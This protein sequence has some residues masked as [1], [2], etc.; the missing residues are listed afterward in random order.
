[1]ILRVF[2]IL[3]VYAFVLTC[4]LTYVAQVFEVDFEG[5]SNDGCV[6]KNWLE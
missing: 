6:A 5:H 2:S 1:M 4:Q 3:C